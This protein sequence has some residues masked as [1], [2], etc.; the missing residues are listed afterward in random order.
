MG[1][2]SLV[3]RVIKAKYFPTDDFVH[4]LIGHN[5]SY[6]WRSL[7]S[8][9]SLVIKGM[10][11]RVGNGAS[12]K[13][14]QDKWLPGVSSHRVLSPRMF[15]SADMNVVDLIDSG[16]AKWKNEVIDSLFIP[17]EAE[18]IKSIPLSATLPVDK[19]VWVETTNGNFTIRSAYKL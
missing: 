15:L 4:A 16:T 12:I 18:L 6:T 14:W 19:I 5:P 2:D 3:Y 10:H 13:I 9:Q 8:A 7:I 17:Y 1:G 11:W